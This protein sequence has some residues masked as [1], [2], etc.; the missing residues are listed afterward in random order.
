[1]STKSLNQVTHSGA[2]KIQLFKSFKSIEHL[3]ALGLDDMV[4]TLLYG[5]EALS[6]SG[7]KILAYIPLW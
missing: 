7:K 5:T 6:L 3:H 2:F 1:M 4:S